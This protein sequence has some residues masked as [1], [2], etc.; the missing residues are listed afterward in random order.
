LLADE[1]QRIFGATVQA[2]G[3]R[4]IL[5]APAP[6]SLTVEQARRFMYELA[7]AYYQAGG[8]L[9]KRGGQECS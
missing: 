8:R 3:Q 2:A 1:Q 9:G 7:A 5:S 4:V 6:T